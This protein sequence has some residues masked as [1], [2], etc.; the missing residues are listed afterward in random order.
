MPTDREWRACPMLGVR[1]VRA[2][3]DYMVK[4]LGFEL[5]SLFEGVAADG[6]AIYSIL[7]RDG[8][9]VHLQIRRRPLWSAPRE[10]IETDIYVRVPDA[11]AVHADLVARGAVLVRPLQDEPY[12]MRDFTVEGPEGHRIAFGSDLG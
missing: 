11:D 7:R 4:R 12:G 10:G 2:A 3:T 5:G 9:E 8:M 6:G 1:D